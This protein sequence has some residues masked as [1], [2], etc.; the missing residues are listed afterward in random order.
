METPRQA[1]QDG[2][3]E[4]YGRLCVGQICP[5][6]DIAWRARLEKIFSSM[7]VPWCESIYQELLAPAGVLWS[8]KDNTFGRRAGD[9]GL[10]AFVDAECPTPLQALAAKC[11]ASVHEIEQTDAAADIARQLENTIDSFQETVQGLDAAMLP[12]RRTLLDKYIRTAGSII[13]K[14]KELQGARTLGL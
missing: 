3:S 7:P 8:R 13:K 12:A 14:K 4:Y 5:D 1:I 6:L 11:L 10:K 2:Y 9:I